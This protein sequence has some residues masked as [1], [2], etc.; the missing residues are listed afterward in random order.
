M[1]AKS[2][3]SF[4]MYSEQYE[5]HL[6]DFARYMEPIEWDMEQLSLEIKRGIDFDD[7]IVCAVRGDGCCMDMNLLQLFGLLKYAAN[8]MDV[9]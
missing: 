9:V 4:D 7:V 8:K 5:N 1:K 6:I 3:S 2:K